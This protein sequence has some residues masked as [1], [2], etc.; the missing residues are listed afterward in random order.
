MGDTPSAHKRNLP[1]HSLPLTILLWMLFG[2]NII[3]CL[4][5][6]ILTGGR[7]IFIAAL[8]KGLLLSA[9]SGAALSGTVISCSTFLL[10]RIKSISTINKVLKLVV[11]LLAVLT[12]IPG[13]QLTSCRLAE[14]LLKKA[15]LQPVDSE[16]FYTFVGICVMTFYLLFFLLMTFIH[17]RYLDDTI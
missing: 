2:L 11:Y 16:V 1:K 3:F 13:G 10:N 17:K 6:S 12:V 7:S 15:I 8:F 5:Y 9:A 4:R 14:Y